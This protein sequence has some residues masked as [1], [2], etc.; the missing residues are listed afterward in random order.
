MALFGTLFR[1]KNHPRRRPKSRVSQSAVNLRGALNWFGEARPEL[2]DAMRER[3]GRA[4]RR[5]P[6]DAWAHAAF[7]SA[8][9]AS[10]RAGLTDDLHEDAIA[11]HEAAEKALALAPKNPSIMALAAPA[12][13][14]EDP[15]RAATLIQQAKRKLGRRIPAAL[16][17]AAEEGARR[18]AG[19]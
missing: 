13:A 4:R 1:K 6:K 19:L 5:K 11:A 18:P 15:Q 8:L 9:I 10:V 3:A 2:L 17:K 16:A 12:L 14:L 7:A